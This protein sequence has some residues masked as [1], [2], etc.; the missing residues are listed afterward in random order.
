[1]RGDSAQTTIQGIIIV[2]DII[3]QTNKCHLLA[4]EDKM[5]GRK[6]LSSTIFRFF[7][8]LMTKAEKTLLKRNIIT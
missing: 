2:N 7:S 3:N 6:V 5:I 8:D 4:V 1:M